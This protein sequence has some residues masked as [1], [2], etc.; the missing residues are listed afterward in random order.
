METLHFSIHLSSLPVKFSY[1]LH[2]HGTYIRWPLLTL[3]C[4]L[5]IL[6]K[7]KHT[8]K[9]YKTVHR[10]FY[11]FRPKVSNWTKLNY[12]MF[13]TFSEKFSQT[14]TLWIL[15]LNLEFHIKP[16]FMFVWMYICMYIFQLLK[17][18]SP[19]FAI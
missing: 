11:S 2:Y 15:K 18:R 16:Q 12:Y 3:L 7:T 13:F 17:T 1:H 19:N 10:T 14:Q 4:N 8:H 9:L 6:D 5:K